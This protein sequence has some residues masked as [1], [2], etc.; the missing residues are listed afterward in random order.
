MALRRSEGISHLEKKVES[1]DKKV[2]SLEGKVESVDKKVDDI[3]KCLGNLSRK[4]EH[5]RAVLH[6]VR[7]IRALFT[8]NNSR[9]N[10]VLLCVNAM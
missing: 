9:C 1:L 10:G 4:V 6:R 8:Y 2:E 7:F 3:Q 5:C